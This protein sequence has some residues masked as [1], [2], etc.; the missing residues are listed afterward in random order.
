[1]R[2][3]GYRNFRV[4]PHRKQLKLAP[5]TSVYC[6]RVGTIDSCL[7]ITDGRQTV[8]NVNDPRI[9]SLTLN[10]YALAVKDLIV[11]EIHHHVAAQHVLESV[12]ANHGQLGAGVTIPF[13]GFMYFSATDNRPMNAYNNTPVAI[14]DLLR[15]EGKRLCSIP[16]TDTKSASLMIPRRPRA[17][18]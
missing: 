3:I 7:A 4:L 14:A 13:A 18:R 16:A 5:Q 15:A 8:F 10:Q 6:Y 1:M 17:L 11:D 2:K 9:K 12:P